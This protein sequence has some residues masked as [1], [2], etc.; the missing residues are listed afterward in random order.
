MRIATGDIDGDGRDEIIVG[1]GRVQGAPG[2]PGGYFAVLD[3]DYSVIAWGQVEWPEY[4]Q[5]NGETRL[6]CGDIDGDGIAEIIIGLGPG[7][8]GRLEVFKL[9]TTS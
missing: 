3:D 4:N 7:G 2:I 6:A 5:I 1:L 8:E 9:T